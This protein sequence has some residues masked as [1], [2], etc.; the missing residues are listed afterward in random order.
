VTFDSR[1]IRPLRP[2]DVQVNGT[3]YGIIISDGSADLDASWVERNRLTE[4]AP[5]AWTDATVAAEAGQTTVI[6]VLDNTEAVLTTHSGLTGTTFPVPVASF[7]GQSAGFIRIGSERDGFRE[8]QAY[9]LKV[10]FTFLETGVYT[11]TGNP[12][13]LV[14]SV[15]MPVATGVYTLTGNNV[16]SAVTMPVATGVYALTGSPASLQFS[17]GI[18]V[19]TGVYTLTGN[20]AVLT[21]DPGEKDAMLPGVMADVIGNRQSSLPNISLNS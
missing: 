17:A 19:A 12:A 8:W 15:N 3:A 18:Q 9:Q 14:F 4:L 2:A 11:L 13:G 21:F 20:A 7:A 6:E 16:G 10:Q 1:A 5:L